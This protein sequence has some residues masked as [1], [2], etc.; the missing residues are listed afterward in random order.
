MRCRKNFR[1]LTNDERQRYVDALADLKTRGVIDQF[2]SEHSNFFGN[3]H[4]Q[5]SFFPWHREFQRRFEDELRSYDPRITIPYWEWSVDNTPGSSLWAADFLG[6]FD[7]AWGLGRSLSGTLPS[8]QDVQDALDAATLPDFLDIVERSIGTLH[9]APHGWVGGVM[10]GAASPGDP[11]FYLHHGFIDVI[12]AQWQL[13]HPAEP[14]V[15]SGGPAGQGLSDPMPP[16]PTTPGDVLDH[17]T[18]N[19]YQYPAGWLPDP[20]R[21]S[22]TTAAV[23]FNDVPEGETTWRAA[24]FDLD[25]CATINLQVVSG[26]TVLTG[27][28]GTTFGVVSATVAADPL[29]DP[30]AR[31]WF[32]YTGTNDG[33][34]ATATVRVR[35]VQTGQEWDIALTANT[36]NRP[37]AVV[38]LAL[39]QSNSMTFDSGIGAGI[40]RGAVL[41][42]SAPPFVDVIEGGNALAIFSF[43][44]DPHAGLGVTPVSGGGRGLANAQLAGYA[45]NPNGW[46]SI[47]EAVAFASGLLSPVTGYDLK[48]MVV[49]TDGQENHGPYTRRYIADVSGMINERVYAIGLGRAEVLNPAALQALCN[50]TN[51]YLY[52]TGDLNSDA[53]F[54]L[55][56][57]YQQVLA[58]VTNNQIVLD[59]EGW[60]AP[61]QEHR[62][63][64]W[65]N[66]TD[67][68]ATA[69]LLTAAPFA[70]RYT[71]ETP[72]GEIIDPGVA[73]THPIIEFSLGSN[74][75]YYRT[76]LP[77][78]IGPVVG[79]QIG[80]W[81]AVLRVDDTYFKRYLASLDNFPELYSQAA[82]HGIRYNFLAQSYS[83]LRMSARLAQTGNE[84][85]ATLT[86]R[87]LVSEY[88]QPVTSGT[89]I[90][91]EMVR[92]DDTQSVLTLTQVEPGVWQTGTVASLSGVYRFRVL[93]EGRTRRGRL[94][95]REQLLTGAVWPGGDRPFPTSDADEG[96][97]DER[98]CRVLL[99]LLSQ[100]GVQRWLKRAEIDPREIEKCVREFCAART[101]GGAATAAIETRLRHVIGDDRLL[102]E[103]IA[104]AEG[105]PD[106]GGER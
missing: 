10:G 69:V 36:I 1:D 47:G 11:V 22:L 27:P 91:A 78:P 28:A 84:P 40:T 64:F 60:I 103:L 17:R 59:P 66:E 104:K 77:L 32:T 3:A 46:T 41:Q 56:K 33:D 4:G 44:H 57:Y 89:V 93:A 62:I 53:Y 81:T 24:L 19:T 21:V 67:I 88:G 99:C 54:R 71:I 80:Q 7:S 2:A 13:L 37:T 102:R 31:M 90:R 9:D 95:T 70:L 18:V 106:P 48:A 39:D 20:P 34:Q 96:G 50:G 58:G 55:A 85:G 61:G 12:W 65:L 15:P 86:L 97:R 43:D 92:P 100:D 30:Q 83:N 16:F 79:A 68:T 72:E 6:G 87:A 26:P 98:L 23:N 101:A 29:L 63:P 49:L 14:F 51:G 25:S 35:C 42:F 74:V 52:L 76:G 75:A 105:L 73:G 5:S 8:A 45:P 82:T 38:A 94:F